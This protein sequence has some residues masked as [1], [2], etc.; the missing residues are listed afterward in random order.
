MAGKPNGHRWRMT[1]TVGNKAEWTCRRCGLVV[2]AW[3][4]P[5][6]QRGEV[7]GGVVLTR[8]TEAGGRPACGG[9]KIGRAHV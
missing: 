2:L 4:Q 9:V 7:W 8:E 3:E 5:T 1:G 6:H